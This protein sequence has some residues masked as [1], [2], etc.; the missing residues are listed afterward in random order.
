MAKRRF[1]PLLRIIAKSNLTYETHRAPQTSA[2]A[3]VRINPR[4]PSPLVVAEPCTEP[5]FCPFLDIRKFAINW[6]GKYARIWAF[7]FRSG[8]ANSSRLRIYGH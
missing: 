5:A 1:E 6:L 8:V 7:L 4:R 3:G 2:G